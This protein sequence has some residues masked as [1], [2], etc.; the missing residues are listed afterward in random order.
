MTS[1]YPIIIVNQIVPTIKKVGFNS[2]NRGGSTIKIF[3][4]KKTRTVDVKNPQLSIP[5]INED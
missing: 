1:K 3:R 2:A 4:L 5:Y